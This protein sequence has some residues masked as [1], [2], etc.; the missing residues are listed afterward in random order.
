MGFWGKKMLPQV[1]KWDDASREVICSAMDEAN[2][3]SASSDFIAK[4]LQLS[5]VRIVVGESE[6]DSTGRAG[7]AMPSPLRSSMRDHASSSMVGRG[8]AGS[9]PAGIFGRGGPGRLVLV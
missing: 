3:L 7:S 6:D 5:S 2:V 8:G 4:E 1:F 9:N